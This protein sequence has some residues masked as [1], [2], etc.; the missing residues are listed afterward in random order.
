[1]IQKLVVVFLAFI[2][3]QGFAQTLSPSSKMAFIQS[4]DET[5]VDVS[6]TNPISLDEV[7]NTINSARS[8][9]NGAIV[10]ITLVGDLFISK[11]P[12][13][14]SGKTILFIN[15]GSIKAANDITASTLI[16]ITNAASVS[17]TSIQNGVLDGSHKF[18]KA[19]SC[20]NTS[21]IH[22]GNLS[23]INCKKGGVDFYNTTVNEAL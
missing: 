10:R 15:N 3:F 4:A 8:K 22:L 14:L 1:M 7:Q 16:T 17:I 9:H 11:Q 5:V 13:V 2:C 21:K 12:L 19:I 23:I 20:F 18:L 6:F